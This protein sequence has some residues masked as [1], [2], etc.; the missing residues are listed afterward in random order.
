MNREE[1]TAKIAEEHEL[2]KVAS[3]KILKT[4]IDSIMDAVADG[5]VVSFPGFG[6]FKLNIRAARTGVNPATGAA[7]EIA[8]TNVVKFT[9]GKE[10]KERLNAE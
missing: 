1:L 2:S 5:D 7:I 8:A 4:V 9:P 6:S 10:F 3:G